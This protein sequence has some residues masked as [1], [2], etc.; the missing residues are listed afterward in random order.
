MISTC[1]VVCTI[2]DYSKKFNGVKVLQK[3][4]SKE[5]LTFM[6]YHAYSSWA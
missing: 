6:G 5:S 3:V 4:F 2:I 1:M